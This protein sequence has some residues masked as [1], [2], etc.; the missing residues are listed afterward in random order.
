MVGL[1]RRA[2]LGGLAASGLAPMAFA[3][4]PGPAALQAEIP[5]LQRIY[6]SLHP[7]LYR[8][9]TPAAFAQRCADLMTALESQTSLSP[10][11]LALSGLP[12]QVRCGHTYANF[13]NQSDTV[14]KAVIDPANKLPFHFVWLASRMVILAKPLNIEGLARGDASLSINGAS[15]GAIQA[16][17]L[18]YMRADGSNDAKR[19]ALLDVA[20]QGRI[21]G[22][23]TGGTSAG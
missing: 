18:P 4:S 10:Q 7:G 11:C 22:Q 5:L 3:T 16:S 14:A 19:R 6:E 2:V 9:Q 8:D 12:A 1:F 15:V 21:Y 20:G 17:L 13:F 23:P